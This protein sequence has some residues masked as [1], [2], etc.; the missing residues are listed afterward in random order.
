MSTTG[1]DAKSRPERLMNL[2]IM[3]LT[4]KQFISKDTIR[5]TVYGEPA[6]SAF[7]RMFDRDK[8]LLRGLGVPIETG[9]QDAWFEDE[10]GYRISPDE[11]AL[12]GI[13]FTADEAA[14]VALAAKVWQHAALADTAAQGLRKLQPLISGADPEAAGDATLLPSLESAAIVADEPSFETFWTAT[15]ERRTVTF[16]YRSAGNVTAVRREVEPWGVV[17]H[18]GRWYVVG[19]DVDRD[20]ERV[21]RLSRVNGTGRLGKEPDAFVVPEGVDL[22]AVTR[23]LAPAPESVEADVLVRSGRGWG[24]RRQAADVQHDVEGPDGTRQW[25]RLRIVGRPSTTAEQV[26]SAG[27]SAVVL[28]PP[29]L[30]STVVDRLTVL[31]EAMSASTPQAPSRTQPTQENP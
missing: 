12:P 13:R 30:R 26:L 19:R 21:F 15:Q 20:Q 16:D 18:S 14:V 3:L 22:Q 9:H 17:R 23:R 8:E 27:S 10:P 7:D 25:D 29:E 1:K 31:L 4:Q 6:G 5:T 24:L 28:S 2:L 11:Y